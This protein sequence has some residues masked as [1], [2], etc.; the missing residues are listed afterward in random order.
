M[1]SIGDDRVMTREK[2]LEKWVL[3]LSPAFLTDLAAFLRYLE[4]EALQKE[5]KDA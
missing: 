1:P 4:E 3:Y 2:F 5:Q